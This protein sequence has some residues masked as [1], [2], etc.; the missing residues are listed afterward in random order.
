MSV[1]RA[2]HLGKSF[3]EFL[4]SLRIGFLFKASSVPQRIPHPEKSVENGFHQPALSFS[5]IKADAASR[6]HK[7]S[8][9]IRGGQQVSFALRQSSAA[10]YLILK[11]ELLPR[12]DTGLRDVL[13][14]C[15]TVLKGKVRRYNR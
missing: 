2:R 12:R 9:R 6:L 14:C 7:K 5:K 4:Y 3:S 13:F 10:R 1:V 11:Q 15:R 8:Y